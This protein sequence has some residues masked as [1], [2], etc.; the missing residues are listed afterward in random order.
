MVI[1]SL[2]LTVLSLT[3]V[4]AKRPNIL[5]IITD[6]QD[7]HMES[8]EHMPLL[9]KYIMDEGTVYNNHFCTIGPPLKFLFRLRLLNLCQS[10]LLSQPCEPLVWQGCTQY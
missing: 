2:L 1:Y 3:C 9:R 5:F 4:V 10:T 7:G 6:D 8:V